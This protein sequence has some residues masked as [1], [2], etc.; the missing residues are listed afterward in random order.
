MSDRVQDGRSLAP[1]VDAVTAL[2]DEG[3]DPH[4]LSVTDVVQRARVSRPTFY[5]YFKDIPSLVREVA[6]Q[7]MEATFSRVPQAAL[8]ESW[9]AFAR[10]TFMTLL[11][12]LAE[13]RR[14]YL[15]VLAISPAI[16][17]TDFIT[18]LS[19]RLLTSSPL[20]P[21]IH[22]RKGP[23]TPRQRADFL[24]AGTV[25]LV[26]QWLATSTEPLED[27]EEMVDRLSSLLLSSS[28]ATEQEIAAV[29]SA[30]PASTP[31]PTHPR[32]TPAGTSPERIA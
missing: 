27:V 7:R 8:G 29:R 10:G 3:V 23:D 18:Y 28:G 11:T 5:K 15:A 1:L 6:L 9:T 32:T 20:G 13:H 2:L 24:A 30:S 4:H 16:V 21:V 14:F 31:I 19:R 12:D 25:W 22:R 17:M 26:Q